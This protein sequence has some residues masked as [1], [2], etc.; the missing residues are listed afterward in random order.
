MVLVNLVTKTIEHDST[1]LGAR[2]LIKHVA[3]C[4]A[5]GVLFLDY[6]SNTA[7]DGVHAA[8]PTDDCISRWRGARFL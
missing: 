3:N 6:D 8:L 2:L 4:P 7:N 1:T 5:V